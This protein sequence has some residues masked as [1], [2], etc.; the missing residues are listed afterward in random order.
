MLKMLNAPANIYIYTLL[1]N[2]LFEDV[3]PIKYGYIPASYVSLP[4]DILYPVLLMEDIPNNHLG[5]F[6]T[7]E[8]MRINYQP[9]LVSRISSINRFSYLFWWP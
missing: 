5:C 9:Q 2:G 1:A 3:R 6:W 8:I 4:E 7:L